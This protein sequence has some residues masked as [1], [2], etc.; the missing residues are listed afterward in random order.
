MKVNKNF[1]NNM[2]SYT[3]KVMNCKDFFE[4]ITIMFANYLG[5][6]KE[7]RT[8]TLSFANK[9]AMLREAYTVLNATLLTMEATLAEWFNALNGVATEE[10]TN[11]VVAQIDEYFCSPNIFLFITNNLKDFVDNAAT[12]MRCPFDDETSYATPNDY[13]NSPSYEYSMYFLKKIAFESAK[14][15]YDYIE[16]HTTASGEIINWKNECKSYITSWNN[17]LTKP[18]KWFNTDNLSDIDL[19]LGSTK[20]FMTAKMISLLED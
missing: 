17:E 15:V 11:N 4:Y 19:V 14:K 5:S 12:D 1:L 10:T 13:F 3:E 18:D 2:R 6:H 9:S 8:E 16:N 20:I 7:A